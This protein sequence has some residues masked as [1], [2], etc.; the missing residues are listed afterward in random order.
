VTEISDGSFEEYRNEYTSFCSLAGSEIGVQV[1]L[2]KDRTHLR[3]IQD[4]YDSLTDGSGK[5]L[6]LLAEYESAPLSGWGQVSDS[7]WIDAGGIG[8]HA[9]GYLLTL[10]DPDSDELYYFANIHFTRG[11]VMGGLHLIG[12]TGSGRI[13]S[14]ALAAAASV[15]DKII[16]GSRRTAAEE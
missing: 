7:R 14:E 10:D 8:D 11:V 1:M 13:E 16:A 9:Y 3:H 15:D 2:P 12:P 4:S 6:A 5:E